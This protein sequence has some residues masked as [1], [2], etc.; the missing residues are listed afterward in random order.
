MTE[1]L[2]GFKISDQVRS[3]VGAS[4]AKRKANEAGSPKKR[5][6]GFPTIER[7]V[8]DPGLAALK[9]RMAALQDLAKSGKSPKEKAGAKKAAAAYKHAV[10]VV[11]F[12]LATKA[13]MLPQE[14]GEG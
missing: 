2:K 4:Q 9:E 5:P 6:V 13:Q 1:D 3:G 10:G 12:L 14:G 8:E 11:D 7:W